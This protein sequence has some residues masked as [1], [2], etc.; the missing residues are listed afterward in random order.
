MGWDRLLRVHSS[1]HR[2]W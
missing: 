2:H 1:W